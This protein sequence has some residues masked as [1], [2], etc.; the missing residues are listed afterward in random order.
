MK[1]ERER[2]NKRE[3]G[4]QIESDGEGRQKGQ[5]FC[6]PREDKRRRLYLSAEKEQFRKHKHAFSS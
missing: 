1:R 3:R 2:G 6:S 4:S 5:Q